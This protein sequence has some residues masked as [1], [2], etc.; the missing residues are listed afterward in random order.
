[1]EDKVVAIEKT[2]KYQVEEQKQKNVL[3]EEEKKKLTKKVDELEDKL[4]QHMYRAHLLTLLP[5]IG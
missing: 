5:P 1:M 2:N 3:L 4:Q